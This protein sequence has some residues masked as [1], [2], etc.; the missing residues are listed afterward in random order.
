MSTNSWDRTSVIFKVG[1]GITI[2]PSANLVRTCSQETFTS[3]RILAH[4]QGF[5]GQV[6][7]WVLLV[8]DQSVVLVSQMCLQVSKRQSS[9]HQT[10]SWG[11]GLDRGAS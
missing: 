6:A 5:V 4:P 11:E 7:W 10:Q 2:I 9:A 8:P 3:H 1:V